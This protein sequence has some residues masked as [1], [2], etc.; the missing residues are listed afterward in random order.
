MNSMSR[1]QVHPGTNVL[2][3]EVFP[4]TEKSLAINWVD[5]NPMPP[6]KD[7]GLWAEIRLVTSGAVTVRHTAVFTHFAD[8]ALDV[9]LLAVT[10]DLRNQSSSDDT[11]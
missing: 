4:P 1:P 3:I 11:G 6:D 10:A 9:A 5:W 7:M 2:A 8:D